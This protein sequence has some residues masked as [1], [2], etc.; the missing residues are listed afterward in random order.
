MTPRTQVVLW[1]AVAVAAAFASW[2]GVEACARR[3]ASVRGPSG[4]AGRPR[5]VALVGGVVDTVYALGAVD[6]LV[7]V[8]GGSRTSYY[9]GTD[10][11]PRILSDEQGGMTNPEAI[12]A[13]RPDYVLAARELVPALSGR[14]LNV[15]EVPQDSFPDIRRFTADLGRMVGREDEARAALAR[16]D[17][18]IAAIRQRVAGLRPVRVYWETSGPGRTWGPGTAVHEM[19]GLAGGE[20][21]Y[22]DARIPRATVSLE[23]IL[24]ADPEVIVISADGADP[25]EVMARQG[26]DRITAV[27]TRRVHRL[28][29]AE[30]AV[31]L[32]SPRCAEC[33]ERTFLRWFH[34][35]LFG[36]PEPR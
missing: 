11:I 36:A 12:L 24:A 23:V 32:Y 34:P 35:E 13:L 5:V 28:P 29:V 9:P 6:T 18:T 8:G 20:N 19:I 27:R 25:E 31:A 2:W 26:W 7:G 1:M 30:R 21:I 17:A 16:M 4:P 3:A 10:D 14:G 15:V 33:C 22:Q